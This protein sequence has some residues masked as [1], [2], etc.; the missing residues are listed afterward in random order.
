MEVIRKDSQFYHL[1]KYRTLMIENDKQIDFILESPDKSLI[2]EDDRGYSLEQKTFRS[3]TRGSIGD[4]L[5][6][7]IEAARDVNVEILQ[8]SYDFFFGGTKRT[9]F[10]ESEKTIQAYK[11]IH[12]LAKEYGLKFSASITNPLDLGDSYGK[13]RNDVGLTWHYHEGA[14]DENGNYDVKMVMQTQWSNNKGPVRLEVDRVK[15]YAFREERFDDTNY[16][17]VNPDE[18]LDISS[19]AKLE[20]MGTEDIS[21]RGNG[22][23][24]ARVRG[25]WADVKSGWNRCL[26]VIVYKTREMD[27]FAD[28]TLDYMKGII[29]LHA[30]AGVT[31]QGFYSDEMH[32]QFDWDSNVHF[33]QTEVTTRYLT[34][35]LAKRYAKLYGKEFEDFGKYLVYFSYRQHDFSKEERDIPVQ[36]IMKPGAEGVYLTWL[37]RKRYFELLQDVVVGLC[38]DVKKYTEEKFKNPVDAHGH[39]TWKESPTLDKNYPEMKWYS[40]R[41]DDLFSRY[42]YHPEYVAS[43]SIIEAVAACYDYFRWNDYFSGGGTDHGEHGYAD[44]NYYTQAFGSSLAVLNADGRGYAG[45]WGSPEPVITR[46]NTIARIFGNGSFR[47]SGRDQYIQNWESRITDVLLIYPLDLLYSEER[48]GS[49]MV[50]YGYCN[51]I[52]ENKFLEFAQVGDDGSIIIKGRSYRAVV[53]LY[54]SFVSQ[55]TIS[56]LEQL[57]NKGGRVLWTSTPPVKYWDQDKAVPEWNSLFGVKPAGE[58]AKPILAKGKNI[59]FD[60]GIN[61]ADMLVPTDMLPDYV[62]RFAAGDGTREIAWLGDT[63]VGFEKKYSGGGQA[64]YL[65][66][67]ARDDQSQSMGTDISTLFDVL[68]YMGAYSKDGAE[69]IS[70]PKEARYIMQRFPNGTVSLANHYRTFY[71]KWSSLFGRDPAQDEEFL[72]GREL[73][74]LEIDL[75]DEKIFNHKVNYAGT[76]T[77][78]YRLDESGKLLGFC[79]T[80]KK[81]TLD[82]K[83]YNFTGSDGW[84]SFAPLDKKLLEDGIKAAVIVYSEKA[85]TLTIPNNFAATNLKGAVCKL[86]MLAVEKEI[87]ISADAEKITVTVGEDMADKNIL[88]YLS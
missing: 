5:R 82:G 47:G 26:A 76:D 7:R 44:R 6:S 34:P 79:G 28:D 11:I 38:V 10:P 1:S 49:W 42:D 88:I 23:V 64:V 62:Y 85:A 24:P 59:R 9:L 21:K 80:G 31:Y 55:K 43:S 3:N 50:Q 65:A 13:T 52:T 35:N 70:R 16:F 14:I 20:I 37:F 69:I 87:P 77:L 8:V 66:F 72:R 48:F 53:F 2:V 25:N 68:C 56:L 15:L 86:N 17:Y 22:S 45:G 74:T 58:A 63:P 83:S 61:T 60:S 71:E 30:K 19:T 29:D 32:I 36:H 33:F 18:I 51:Y 4:S 57:L 78:T 39:A 27:Y 73:P 75:K 67:R 84:F 54:Q 46:M 41:R 81:I 12:D 40:L